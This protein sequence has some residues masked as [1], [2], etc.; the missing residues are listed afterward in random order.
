MDNLFPAG[1]TTSHGAVRLAAPRSDPHPLA[2]DDDDRSAGRRH[3][4]AALADRL[5]G[6]GAPYL[7]GALANPALHEDLALVLLR[8]RNATPEVLRDLHESGRFRRSVEIRLALTSHP[9]TPRPLAMNLVPYLPWRDLARLA[10]RPL[11][12][13][14]IRRLA[15]RYLEDR[16]ED[17][18]LG[19]QTYLA[20]TAGRAVIAA[21]VRKATEPVVGAVLRNPRLTEDDLVAVCSRRD[22]PPAVLELVSRDPAWTRRYRVRCA[23]VDH[24]RAPLGVILGLLTGLLTPDLQE[25]A[26]RPDRPAVVRLAARRILAR[27][28]RDRGGPPRK[29]PDV[30]QL[31]TDDA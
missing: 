22:T 7:E 5:P 26:R 3:T 2:N 12:P 9:R 16:F 4:A 14:P 29:Q 18:A 10:D 17:M 15:L 23:L 11:V 6:A 24:E 20:R 28:Y 13:P 21:L 19:E 8:N 27:R 31:D 30:Y 1:Q 25:I